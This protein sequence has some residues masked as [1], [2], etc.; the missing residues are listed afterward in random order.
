ML[1]KALTS[2]EGTML[3]DFHDDD[4]FLFFCASI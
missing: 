1:T 3:S 2:R 4:I